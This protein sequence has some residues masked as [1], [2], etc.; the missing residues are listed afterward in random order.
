MRCSEVQ[1]SDHLELLF[2]L[3]GLGKRHVLVLEQFFEQFLDR[4]GVHVALIVLFVCDVEAVPQRDSENSFCFQTTDR[5]QYPVIP[6]D[7]Y[8]RVCGWGA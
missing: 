6:F 3:V 8:L 4:F 5:D 7:A 1:D 2:R